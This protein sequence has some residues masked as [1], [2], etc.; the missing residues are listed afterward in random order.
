[1]L[2]NNDVC[3]AVPCLSADANFVSLINTLLLLLLQVASA[4]LKLALFLTSGS[5][6]LSYLL[7]V[8]V[9]VHNEA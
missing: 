2:S 3:C 1:M 8:R 6:T 4:T 5:S 9:H 7:Q